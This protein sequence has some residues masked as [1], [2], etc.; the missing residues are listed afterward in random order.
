MRSLQNWVRS[1]QNIKAHTHEK[2]KNLT[3]NTFNN[4]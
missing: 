1:V 2:P 3:P 4:S